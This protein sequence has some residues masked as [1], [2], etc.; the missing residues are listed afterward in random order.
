MA[1][2]EACARSNYVRF[3][4]VT[5]AKIICG[6]AG[7]GVELSPGSDGRYTVLCP[8]GLP[9]EILDESGEELGDF[10]FLIAALMEPNEVIV[11]I[12]GG[13]EKLCYVSGY[14]LAVRADG[15]CDSIDLGTAIMEIAK[16]L[17]PAGVTVT[18]PEY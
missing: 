4:D 16:G 17:A 1:N 11:F 9:R 15:E 7:C 12:E 10:P 8:E 18:E 3:T 2:Y 6:Q 5:K 13:H 14:G